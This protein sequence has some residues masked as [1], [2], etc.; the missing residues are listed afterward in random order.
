[1]DSKELTIVGYDHTWQ[2]VVHTITLRMSLKATRMSEEATEH[3]V[4]SEDE[5]TM[6][7][8]FYPVLACCTTCQAGPIPTVDEF[9][10]LPPKAANAWYDAVLAVNPEALP[11]ALG[12]VSVVPPEEKKESS[13][14][15][16]TAG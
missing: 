7:V 15:G 8:T 16:S 3:P 5:Q 9:F 1:M 14:T 2:V 13:P 12:G 10:D 4:G 6:R 11:S